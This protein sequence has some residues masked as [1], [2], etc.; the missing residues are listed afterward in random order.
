MSIF[1]GRIEGLI[2]GNLRW[3]HGWHFNSTDAIADVLS[4]L[5]DAASTLWT[6]ATNGLEH[7]YTSEVQTTNVLVRQLNSEYLTTNV[8][9]AALAITGSASGENCPVGT[10]LVMRMTGDAATKS[11]R[12]YQKLPPPAVSGLSSLL[13][14]T[15]LLDSLKAVFDPFF[16]SMSGATAYSA[17]TY[18]RLPNRQGDPPGTQHRI[19]GYTFTNKPGQERAR[20]KKQQETNSVSGTI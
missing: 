18:N 12:G 2:G 15:G 7:L 13:W 11:D 9:T 1:L 3:S 16:A 19:D 8:Q 20:Y 6:T 10:S 14:S 5:H 4:R 17:F